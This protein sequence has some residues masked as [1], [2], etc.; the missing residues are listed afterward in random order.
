MDDTTTDINFARAAIANGTAATIRLASGLTQQDLSHRLDVALSTVVKWEGGQQ[1]SKR[2]AIQYGR[3]LRQL[4]DQTL[5]D[6]TES[7]EQ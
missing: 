3:L 1:P 7:T 4:S 2:L 6:T 5:T